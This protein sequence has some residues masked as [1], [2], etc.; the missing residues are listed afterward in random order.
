MYQ[1]KGP[2]F[3]A[4]SL[5]KHPSGSWSLPDMALQRHTGKDYV[6]CLSV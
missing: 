3:V 6:S 2:G 4:L 1:G 5:L